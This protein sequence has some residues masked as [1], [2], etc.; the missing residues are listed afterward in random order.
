MNEQK[1]ILFSCFL[2]VIGLM[3]VDFFNPSL[4]FILKEFNASQESIK[5]LIVVYMAILG[6]SQF[7]YGSIS[8]HYGRKPAVVIGFIISI[9]GLFLSGYSEKISHLY[10]SR[11]IT[12]FGAASFTVIS[13]A[14]IVDVFQDNIKLKK[15]FSYFSMSSQLSPALA[16][17]FGGWLQIKYNWHISFFTLAV[18]Y[19][20]GLII[21][22]LTMGETRKKEP[23][24]TALLT[25]YIQLTKNIQ[26]IA[27][28][29]ASS[30]IFSFTIGYYATSP[31]IFHNLGYSPIE[32]SLFFIIYSSG[33]IFGSW[34][35]GRQFIRITSKILYLLSLIFYSLILIFFSL[36]S[37]ETPVTIMIFSFLL[38]TTSG[39]TAPLS[40]I[41]CME[42]VTN[43]KGAA[44]ALQGALK[45]S[46]TG[47]FMLCF[48]L[49][50]LT[51]FHQLIYVF[52]IF[53]VALLIIYFSLRFQS[54]RN[55]I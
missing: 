8:D 33:I 41:L 17:V 20:I 5:N 39:V 21:V 1:T 50:H 15:A 36:L 44:S 38:A 48:D 14:I 42:N 12:A 27:F 2:L 46:F 18:I 6:I 9:V 45:M 37:L 32:N 40:L 26:F 19:F 47:V 3:A 55:K 54:C 24:P 23:K 16:P 22:L 13:R 51:D 34:L 53:T 35:L 52:M 31:Y 7:F 49:F 25:P 10:L 29:I 30:L 28:S 43:N 4:P 11:I